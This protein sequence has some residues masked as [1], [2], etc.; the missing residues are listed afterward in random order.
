[1]ASDSPLMQGDL[2]IHIGRTPGLSYVELAAMG[3]DPKKW[4]R[5]HGS[6]IWSEQRLASPRAL[7]QTMGSVVRFARVIKHVPIP[8]LRDRWTHAI[9]TVL[10]PHALE[11]VLIKK[12]TKTVFL[13]AEA[14][15]GMS[16]QLDVQQREAWK[17]LLAVK[18]T[19]RDQGHP[20]R[21]VGG[22]GV[23][24]SAAVLEEGLLKDTCQEFL[25][26]VWKGDL[27]FAE[28]IAVQDVHHFADIDMNR[29]VRDMQRGMLPPKIA[30]AMVNIAVGS[31]TKKSVHDPFSGVGTVLLAGMG[32]GL[33]MSG[34][35]LEKEA[36]EQ[37]QQNADW[38]REHAGLQMPI[39][40]QSDARTPQ[41][42]KIPH[43]ID[44]I[45]A[46]GDLGPIVSAQPTIEQI[47]ELASRLSPLYMDVLKAWRAVF[48]KGTPIVLALPT[49]KARTGEIGVIPLDNWENLGYRPLQSIR[50]VAALPL[51]I[52]TDRKTINYRRP[53]QVVGREIV[54]LEMI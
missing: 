52:L 54:A 47:R 51:S 24:P 25:L 20:I 40:S 43:P 41:T 50:S 37:T 48:P 10:P 21:I 31:D 23:A 7:M 27:V 14:V 12:Q 28:T 8:P 9:K 15:D 19:L 18:K 39:V 36:V 4:Y 5:T 17:L 32:R 45:V 6:W 3:V 13:S 42:W 33:T 30:R 1:M 11:K 49:W 46:E 34:S 53:E 26:L 35:D 29:P 22:K 16:A 44:A 2:L 38:M